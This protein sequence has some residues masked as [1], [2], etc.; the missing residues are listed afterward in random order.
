MG[1][2]K[3]IKIIEGEIPRD[4]YWLVRRDDRG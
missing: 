4:W 2:K 1:M 3:V